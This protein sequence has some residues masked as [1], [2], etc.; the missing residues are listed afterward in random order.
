MPV[1]AYHLQ[2]VSNPLRNSAITFHY[3]AKVHPINQ[4]DL[5]ECQDLLGQMLECSLQTYPVQGCPLILGLVESGVILSALMQQEA[6][7]R[8]IDTAWICT[9]RRPATGVEI[10]EQHSHAPVH[11]FPLP[12]YRPDEVW[13]VEDEVTTGRTIIEVVFKLVELFQIRKFRFFAL[14]DLRSEP[15]QRWFDEVLASADVQYTLDCVLRLP[16]PAPVIPALP[17]SG[18]PQ[19][20]MTVTPAQ[21]TDGW[22]LRHLRPALTMQT[23]KPFDAFK[24]LQGM[25]L[26]IGEVMDLA[27]RVMLQNSNITLQHV[28]ISPWSIDYQNIFDCLRIDQRFHLYNF[29]HF[30][31]PI[32]ILGDPIDH[33]VRH[34]LY[35]FLS[36]RGCN[37]QVIDPESE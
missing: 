1:R 35:A 18:S 15:E 10:I 22:Y 27:V 37:V 26:V 4:F 36:E 16:A 17:A 31:A 8:R 11:V 30:S 32:S 12:D 33:T 13:I 20:P 3:L 7:R 23:A 34:A 28:T 25:L 14:A 21:L 19:T 2:R 29:T 24:E 6:S 9:T 5:R